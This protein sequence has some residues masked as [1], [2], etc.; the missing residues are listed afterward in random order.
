[1]EALAVIWAPVRVLARVAEERRV[2]LGFIVTALAAVVGLISAGLQVLFGGFTQAQFQ[3]WGQEPPPGFNDLLPAIGVLTVILAVVSPFITW[4]LVS[5]LMQLVTRF[6]SGTGPFSGMLAVVGVAQVPYVIV[7]V[8]GIPITGL[9]IALGPESS[10]TTVMNLLGF[11]LSLAALLWFAAL[12][13]VGAAF[14]RRIGYGESTGSCAIS[15]VGCVGIIILVVIVI[16]AVI[17]A[18]AGT[19]NSAGAT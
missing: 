4:L 9:R 3:S 6:F 7:G 16:I 19:L 11:L 17:V 5:G 12:V 18:V 14:A 2:L 10:A 15:C 8:I 13:V 1:L